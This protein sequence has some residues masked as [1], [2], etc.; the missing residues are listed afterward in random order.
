MKRELRFQAGIHR[1]EGGE[2]NEATF[3]VMNT[4]VNRNHWGVSN[5]ALEEALPTLHNKPLG[6]GPEYRQ[7]HPYP[8]RDCFPAAT[9][10]LQQRVPVYLE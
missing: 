8:E 9:G 6:C 1:A 2:V 3:Y 7:D 10:K 4:T 5:K